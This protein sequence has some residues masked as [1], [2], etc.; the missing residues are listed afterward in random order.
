M[1]KTVYLPDADAGRL[2][3]LIN[4]NNKLVNTYA[5][6]LGLTP[7]Q[8][9]YI[10]NGLK[11]FTFILACMTSAEKLYHACVSYKDGMNSSVIGTVLK[12]P[13]P[14]EAPTGAPT[15]MVFFGLFEWIDVL[16]SNIKLN[17]AYSVEMGVDLDIIGTPTIINWAIAKPTKVKVASAAGSVRGSYLKGKA[18]GARVECKRGS[19]T[20]FTTFSNVFKASFVDD[21]PNL[22]P[23]QPETRQYRIW[24]LVNDDVVGLVSSI[25]TITVEA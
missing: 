18:N 3:W 20:T 22:I 13:P 4:F 16:V 14:F 19:E 6:Q 17:S 1:K 2:T 23:G 9:L 12:T 11:M 7:A 8:L 24:Y 5:A 25:V 15:T 21:R 10:L